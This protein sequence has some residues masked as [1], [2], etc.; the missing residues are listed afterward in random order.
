M[1]GT[2]NEPMPGRFSGWMARA[3]SPA[4]GVEIGASAL[5][6][7]SDAT[8]FGKRPTAV[9]LLREDFF[10]FIQQCSSANMAAS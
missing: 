3:H 7:G 2:R 1:A 8:F 5:S 9:I 10:R 4:G 6:A